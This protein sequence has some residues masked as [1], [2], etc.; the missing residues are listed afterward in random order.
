MAYS[1]VTNF[2]K[3][4]LYIAEKKEQERGLGS[5]GSGIIK[6]VGDD[7]KDKDLEGRKVAFCCDGWSQYAVKNYEDVLIFDNKADLKMCATAFINPLTALCVKYMLLDRNVKQFVFMGANSTLGHIFLKIALRKGLRPL[8]IVQTA[9]EA[10]ELRADVTKL[11]ESMILRSDAHDFCDRFEN[12]ICS[13]K[14]DKEGFNPSFL[15]D[16]VGSELSGCLFEKMR[17]GSEM[18]LLGNLSN[19]CLKLSTTEFFMHNK[20]LRGF[21]LQSYFRDE[22][23]A[24]RR[25]QLFQIIQDDINAGGEYFGA[26]IA[27]EFKFDEFNKAL[28]TVE[29]VMD[30]GKVLLCI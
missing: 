9:A 16:A 27:R 2:D 24:D 29:Q 15:I 14:G 25:K 5:E 11:E 4:S 13:S 8:A 30:R 22:L 6:A 17:P 21:N 18:I 20:R 26:A 3:A 28:D 23:S 10:D 12:L 7:L 1:P 19:A